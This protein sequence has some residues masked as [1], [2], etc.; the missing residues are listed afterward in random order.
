MLNSKV[1]RSEMEREGSDGKE[2]EGEG[3][4]G[5]REGWREKR[6]GREKGEL[7]A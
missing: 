4:W 7:E 5:G 3:G 6:R 2:G 1:G